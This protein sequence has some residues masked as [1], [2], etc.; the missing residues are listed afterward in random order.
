M[1]FHIEPR[2]NIKKLQVITNLNLDHLFKQLVDLILSAT[3]VTTF[4]KVVDLLPPPT[5]GS[6]QLEWPQ[7][8]GSILEVGSNIHDIIGSDRCAISINLHKPTLVDQ[9][10]D[11]LEVWSSPGNVGL[12]DTKHIDG[13]LV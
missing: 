6:V 12:A 10:P 9:L 1:M 8:V 7:E 5:S 2:A 3:E 4:D 13:S 11:R